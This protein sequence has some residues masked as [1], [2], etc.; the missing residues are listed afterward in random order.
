[1]SDRR[2]ITGPQDAVRPVRPSTPAPVSELRGSQIRPFFVKS[3]LSKNANGLA[4]L[5]VADT[6][7]EVGV[8][9][10]RPIKGLFVDRASFS[11]EAKFLPYIT[12]PNEVLYNGGGGGGGGGGANTVRTGLTNIEQKISTFVESAFLPALLLEKY[13]KST[14]DVFVNVLSFNASTCSMLNLIAWVT[15]C[16]SLALV[17][18]GVEIRDMVTC[19]HV[20]Q[21][22]GSVHMDAHAVDLGARSSECVAAFMTMKNAEMLA[23]WVQGDGA[24]E[25]V[26]LSLVEGCR[27]MAGVVRSNLNGFLLEQTSAAS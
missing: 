12:Q 5:E 4:Y 11:V 26:L 9:G 25:G 19:G 17:D 14:I 22:L 3:G 1:M 10:P 2:R 6:I 20:R 23:F 24:Q 15:N 18:S 21:E 13:P 27:D 8:F 16:T 7:I